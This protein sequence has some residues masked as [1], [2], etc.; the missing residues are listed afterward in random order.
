MSLPHEAALDP[1]LGDQRT[2]DK[3]AGLVVPERPDQQNLASQRDNVTRHVGRPA[4]HNLFGLMMKDRN[5][6]FR[7][8]ALDASIHKLVEH[9]VAKNEDLHSPPL[10]RPT[11][12]SFKDLERTQFVYPL[13]EAEDNHVGQVDTSSGDPGRPKQPAR[14]SPAVGG[15]AAP[16]KSKLNR[17]DRLRFIRPN[18]RFSKGYG[19]EMEIPG[20]PSARF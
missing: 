18:R 7:R 15:L 19:R 1:I 10:A 11:T 4:E 6:R 12:N 9:H 8:N 17:L 13:A 2:R 20:P 3:V 14:G 5:W 16:S